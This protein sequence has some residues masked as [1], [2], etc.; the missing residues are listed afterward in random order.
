VNW[1]INDNLTLTSITADNSGTDSTE[2]DFDGAFVASANSPIVQLHP[3]RNQDFDYFSQELR[4]NGSITDNLDF[5]VG[6]TYYDSELDYV[7]FTNNIIQVPF[8]LPP[9]VPCAAVI[10]ILRD[11]PNPEIGNS[12]CQFPNQRSTQNAGEEVESTA[13]FASLTWRPTDTLEFVVGA[14]RIDEEKDGQNS[15]LDHS[16]GTFDL[17]GQDPHDFSA[18]PNIQGASYTVSDDWQDTITT[19]SANWAFMENARVYASYS[20]GF[21]SGGFSIRSVNAETAPYKPETAEQIEVGVK[22]DWLDG[23]L[24]FNVAYYQL[25]RDGG[26]FISIITLPPTSI[27]GTNTIINNGGTNETTGWEVEAAWNIN[28]NFSLLVNGGTVD[29]DNGSFTLTCDVVDG[30]TGSGDPSG[31]IRQLG[32]NSDSRQPE[33]SVSATLA[34]SQQLGSGILTANAGY[35]KVGEFLLVNTGAGP[36]NRLFEGGYGQWDA[37]IGYEMD[38]NDG[39]RLAFSF[40]G[41]NLTDAEFK[42]QAL[43]LGGPNAGF[44]GWGAPRTIAFE[45]RYSR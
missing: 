10:P 8:G 20:E 44:Q 4:L 42:E 29:V 31:T 1:D 28:D 37:Q 9:G 32:G 38:I 25:E 40:Y 11:N 22:T 23:A 2:S 14:R 39:D 19:A 24:R 6:Y 41:K 43:F 5:M 16:N 21:R 3:Q 17:P 34:Y 15:Y 7:Q 12:L 27:P 33:Y 35:K 30:C 18:G 13:Y 45:V 26:Q 36:D